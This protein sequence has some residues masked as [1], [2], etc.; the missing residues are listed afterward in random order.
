V[1]Q[2]GCGQANF[3]VVALCLVVV[4]A[5]ASAVA[6]IP[7]CFEWAER[8]A[9]AKPQA[10]V[11]RLQIE[12]LSY[13]FG[14]MSVMCLS[15]FLIPVTRHSVL[16]AAMGWSPVHALRIHIWA[17][18]ASFAFML[19]HG[20]ILVPVW[21]AMYEYP[22]WQQVVPDRRCWTFV[23]TDDA[24]RQIQPSCYRVFA[25]WT[26][27]LAA[28]FYIALWGTSL[29]WV[30]RRNYRLFYVCH[31][32]LGTLTILG[33]ILH[34]HWI[35]LLL[36][37]SITYY[38]ASTS[39]TLVQ[40]LASRCRGGVS[41]RA[42]RTIPHSN[43]CV[44]VHL[45]ADGS[46][47]AQLKHV[48]CRFVKICVPELSLV[49]HPFDVYTAPSISDGG[50][51]SRDGSTLRLLFRPVG[52]FTKGLARSLTSFR[53][54]SRAPTPATV[55]VDGL[56]G[57]ASKCRQAL[58]HDCITLVAG[59][60]AV[61][62]YLSLLP[63]L[64][65]QM[66]EL[67]PHC[68]HHGD[69][70]CSTKKV[71]LHWVCRE[72]G[73]ASFVAEEYLK[74]I[75]DGPARVCLS[76]RPDVVIKVHVYV[77]GAAVAL[78]N[79]TLAME[80][81]SA[82]STS[83]IEGCDRADCL[84]SSSRTFVPNKPSSIRQYS[85]IDGICEEAGGRDS[86]TNS[87]AGDSSCEENEPCSAPL[88][89]EAGHPME[90]SRM[91]PG[92]CAS[93]LGNAPYFVALS[94]S[95]W[96]GYWYLFAMDPYEEKDSTYYGMSKMTWI[97][98]FAVLMYIAFGALVE[99]IVLSYRWCRPQVRHSRPRFVY[100]N[101]AVASDDLRIDTGDNCPVEGTCRVEGSL[102]WGT[103]ECLAPTISGL[104]LE[105]N[106]TVPV[107]YHSSRPSG[108]QIFEDARLSASPGVFMCG[109]PSLTGMV[110]MEA[111]K[112]NSVFGFTRYCLYDEP[113]EL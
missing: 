39:P 71:V 89:G 72:P 32:V 74:R 12:Y 15:F 106:R 7:R 54:A 5:V 97:T 40:A 25:N 53:H 82:L 10:D 21:F 33:M 3:N 47:L 59:G 88:G 73:L 68:H 87:T 46:V 80:D 99:A 66:T 16:L 14:W 28:S 110:K 79:P 113:Y 8:A 102:M 104:D 62:P 90:L 57:G 9:S 67:S 60:V 70:E 24:Y 91:L 50:P 98:L 55:L 38:L 19:L 45:D 93:P 34:M 84:D 11:R 58:R 13:M 27:L 29:N 100:S 26:G 23:F 6:Y 2:F 35:V 83:T 43:G 85:T 20:A 36:V 18:Y 109:P 64:L 31:V 52:P 105:S 103:D 95:I 96:S 86:G 76:A 108:T 30:R 77:T 49:W 56:Y 81:S 51:A 44:E 107:S 4:P 61:T 112:E 17:G 78:P 75:L 69:E 63:A 65:R 42:V 1:N 101:V 111:A 48:P 92:R 37:P 22:V 41:V 94:V